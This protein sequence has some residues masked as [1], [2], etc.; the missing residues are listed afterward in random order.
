MSMVS[1]SLDMDQLQQKCFPDLTFRFKE[2]LQ[3]LVAR[4]F[5]QVDH[6]KFIS[7]RYLKQQKGH[8]ERCARE[9]SSWD[10]TPLNKG[11]YALTFRTSTHKHYQIYHCQACL[12]HKLERIKQYF[13]FFKLTIMEL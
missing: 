9:H 10:Y 12:E 8:C 11:D 2:L 13:T 7:I 3:E 5:D 4:L 6:R 1:L